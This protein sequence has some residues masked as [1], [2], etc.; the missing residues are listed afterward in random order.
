[1]NGL[2][3]DDWSQLRSLGHRMV[4]DMIDHLQLLRNRPVWRKL[5]DATRA[6]LRDA[7]LPAG[8]SDPERVYDEMLRDVA[9]HVTGNTHPMFMGWVHGGGTPV[10]MLAELLAGALNANC[11]GRDHAGIELE[12]R[13]IRWAAE[14]LSMPPDSTGLLVTGSSMANFIAVL[15]ARR[16][17]LGPEI[18][19]TGLASAPL[20]AYAAHTAHGCIPRAFDMAGL[21]TDALRPLPTTAA[22][23]LDVGALARA[24]A[25]D[26][27]SGH[28]PFLVVG[29]A[30]TVDVGAIDDLDAIA[31]FC[32][33]ERLWFHVDGAFGALA[34]LSARHRPRLRGM[35]RADSLAFDFHKWAQV[36]YD[37]G[38]ILVADPQALPDTFAQSLAY[39]AR[40][41]RGLAGN[42]PWPTDLGPDLSRGFRALKVSMTLQT[43]GTDALARVVDTA[44]DAARHLAARIE[45]EPGLE[46]LA[47]V[48]LNIVCF[49]VRP[50]PGEDADRL[51]SDLVADLQEAGL[52][53]PSTT[54]LAGT[55][56]IRAAI[57]NH[58]TTR[59]DTD[60]LVDV[61]LDAAEIRRGALPRTPPRGAP[62]GS[63]DE[64]LE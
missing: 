24:V 51:Q 29:T 30:G 35:E 45:R 10:G 9:P 37:A 62:L 20:T 56:A 40:D 25:A 63:H 48:T 33:S 54:T 18:R 50:L 3:P 53:A 60:K 34:A 27:A 17:A 7:P 8:P 57:V 47:P 46:L 31:D 22:H 41:D 11:G 13:V 1:M 32:A 39:L 59:H 5:P 38:C 28:R 61:L 58:R 16:A 26:R 19:R 21:G 2:D 6:R 12:R 23:Q 42:A 4:D 15:A 36:P 44:C 49:R 52:A 43:Y 64:R 55:R 14:A